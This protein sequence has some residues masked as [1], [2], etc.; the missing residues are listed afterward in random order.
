LGTLNGGWPMISKS[1][2]QKLGCKTKSI[3]LETEREV[4][5]DIF[6]TPFTEFSKYY[7]MN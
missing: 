7:L 2:N 5:S 1:G 6:V 3:L 4:K